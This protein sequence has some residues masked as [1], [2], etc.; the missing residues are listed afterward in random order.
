MLF[1]NSSQWFHS[2][3][4]R[5]P[6]FSPEIQKL[7]QA[8]VECHSGRKERGAVL[9]CWCWRVMWPSR[10]GLVILITERLY[11]SALSERLYLSD[12]WRVCARCWEGHLPMIMPF[13]GDLNSVTQQGRDTEGCVAD[14][15]PLM[16]LSWSCIT[17]SSAWPCFSSLHFKGI[18]LWLIF[19]GLPWWISGK[20]PAC[21]CKRLRFNPWVRMISWRKELWL[22]PVF[23]PGKSHGQR[24]SGGLQPTGLQKSQT[25]LSD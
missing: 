20:E 23:L 5:S 18:N 12:P 6:N 14:Q 13:Q 2:D 25:Q 11:Q 19:Y 15:D 8:W 10:F 24:K 21:Q 3:F 4:S 16:G 22:T 9:W 7:F 1:V 17:I